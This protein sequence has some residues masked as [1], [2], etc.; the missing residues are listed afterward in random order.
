MCQLHLED[1]QRLMDFISMDFIGPPEVISRGNQYALTVICML[2]YYVTYIPLVDK[3]TAMVVSAYLK[4][5]YCRI[6]R[7]LKILSDN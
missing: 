6:R 5:K 4:E 1:P 2:T 3:S 7:K